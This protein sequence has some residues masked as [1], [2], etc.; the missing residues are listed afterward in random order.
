MYRLRGHRDLL[1]MQNAYGRKRIQARSLPRTGTVN[2]IMF[3]C[4]PNTFEVVVKQKSGLPETFRVV[5]LIKGRLL[6][7][8]GVNERHVERGVCDD[9]RHIIGRGTDKTRW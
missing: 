4:L 6:K 2:P 7:G 8:D 1:I 9:G 3:R 5:S